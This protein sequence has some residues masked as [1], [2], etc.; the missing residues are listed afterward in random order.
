MYRKSEEKLYKTG[1][2]SYLLKTGWKRWCP[3][4]IPEG[5]PGV[6]ISQ[7]YQ[8]IFLI[9]HQAAPSRSVSKEAHSKTGSVSVAD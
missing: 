4:N 9:N 3:M 2:S 6:I 1:R 7:N 8:L 5:N